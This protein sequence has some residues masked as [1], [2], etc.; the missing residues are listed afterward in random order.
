MTLP[1]TYDHLMGDFKL[2]PRQ[3]ASHLREVHGVEPIQA[4]K[5]YEREVWH[6]QHEGL[7]MGG[8][9][10]YRYVLPSDHTSDGLRAER[11]PMHRS[12]RSPIS[13]IVAKKTFYSGSL[14]LIVHLLEGHHEE[15][16]KRERQVRGCEHNYVYRVTIKPAGARGDVTKQWVCPPAHLS[17]AVDSL[18]EM[19]SAARAAL[20]F[21]AD[22]GWP[23]EEHAAFSELGW[24][25]GATNLHAW[26]R[27]KKR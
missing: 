17:H 7:H 13:Q 14:V 10:G 23:V 3:I 26:P 27:E 9:S 1:A 19:R 16:R 22:E 24:H 21:A 2:R 18:A 4:Q 15:P 25:V 8:I 5:G 12:S 11:S 20:S 6:R